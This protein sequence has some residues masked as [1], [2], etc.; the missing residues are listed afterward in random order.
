VDDVYISSG[1]TLDL[2]CNKC[3]GDKWE[4][5]QNQPITIIA[6]DGPR[7]YHIARVIARNQGWILHKDGTATCPKCNGRYPEYEAG[8]E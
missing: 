4:G 8:K 2:Y 3:K 7:C 6:T 1:Y 5:S